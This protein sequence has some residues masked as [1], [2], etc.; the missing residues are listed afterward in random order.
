MTSGSFRK[1]DSRF[2]KQNT[3]GLQLRLQNHT[4]RGSLKDRGTPLFSNNAFKDKKENSMSSS[5]LEDLIEE[6]NIKYSDDEEE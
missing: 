5:E 4:L 2:R 3:N 1:S 6:D